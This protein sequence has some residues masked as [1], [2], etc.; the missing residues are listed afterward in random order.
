[1]SVHCAEITVRGRVVTVPATCVADS[2]IVVVGKLVKM[3]AIRDE[4]WL[5]NDV[6]GDPELLIRRLKRD[7]LGA[8]LLTF[9]QKLPEVT[10]KF[11]YPME[12]DNLA[13][14]PIT[15]FEEWWEKRISQVTRKNVRRAARRGVIVQSVPFDDY[16]VRGIKGIYDETPLRQ[17]RRFWHYGKSLDTIRKE[18]STFLDK[19]E[20]IGAYY[21]G[22]LIGFLKMVRIGNN[23]SVMQ[24]LSKNEHYDK[25]PGN[26]LIAKAVEI[27]AT[28][29]IS[30]FIYGQY[31]YGNNPQSELTEFKRRNGFE[32]F[33]VP[34]YYVPLTVKGEVV[35]KSNLH[36]GMR[37]FLPGRL[38]AAL[39]AARAKLYE[40]G[41]FGFCFRGTRGNGIRED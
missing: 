11:D 20:L 41:F 32:Q 1:M 23:S 4:H 6:L 5:Q 19:S 17:G 3:A 31:S 27:C 38:E 28:K 21:E 7:R 13:A 10:P 16:L 24:I 35:L 8:D 22:E 18:N 9:A 26:A 40:R 33:L 30:H 39:L 15:T 25:R 36:L 12:W 29:G 37:R 2:T 14:I 34:R